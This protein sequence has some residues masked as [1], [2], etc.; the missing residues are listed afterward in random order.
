[1]GKENIP[2]KAPAAERVNSEMEAFINWINDEQSMD[3][4]L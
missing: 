3:L 4:V 1:M 2:F